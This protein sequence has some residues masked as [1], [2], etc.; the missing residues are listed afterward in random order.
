VSVL[1]RKQQGAEV[2]GRLAA[3]AKVEAIRGYW[4][5]VQSRLIKE[6]AA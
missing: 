1:E 4:L 6:I 3:S 5:E 2:A